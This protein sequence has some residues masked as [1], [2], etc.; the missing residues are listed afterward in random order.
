[1]KLTP[2]STARLTTRLQFSASFGSSQTPSPTIRI[3]PKP[4]RL[5]SRSPPS[6]KDV[7]MISFRCTGQESDAAQLHSGKGSGLSAFLQQCLFRLFQRDVVR[8]LLELRLLVVFLFRD[9]FEEQHVSLNVNMRFRNLPERR[10]KFTSLHFKGAARL[11]RCKKSPAKF[12]IPGQ[13]ALQAHDPMLRVIDR[14]IA[15]HRRKDPCFP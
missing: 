6:F 2:S 10:S 14:H 11:Q 12:H 8:K 5:T 15:L 4:R 7:L 13:P 3:A 1:M 9:A